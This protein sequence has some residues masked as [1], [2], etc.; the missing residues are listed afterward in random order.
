MINPSLSWG[1]GYMHE[2]D[3]WPRVLFLC[4]TCKALTFQTVPQVMNVQSTWKSLEGLSNICMI[5]CL[6]SAGVYRECNV[7][8]RTQTLKKFRNAHRKSRISADKYW[9]ARSRSLCPLNNMDGIN[10]GSEW[11]PGDIRAPS[12]RLQSVLT[13][14]LTTRMKYCRG[15]LFCNISAVNRRLCAGAPP[16]H[17]LAHQLPRFISPV[18][19]LLSNWSRALALPHQLRKQSWRSIWSNQRLGK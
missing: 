18:I 17:P 19:P 3:F 9:G 7:C 16:A 5:A 6:F 15:M 1:T 8:H 4:A 11:R 13:S 14:G 12:P 2:F 10:L